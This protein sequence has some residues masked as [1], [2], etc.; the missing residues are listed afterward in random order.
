MPYIKVDIAKISSYAST[1]S[2]AEAK[3]N[4]IHSSFVTSYNSMDP[5]VMQFQEIS[6]RAQAIYDELS[7]ETLLLSRMGNFLNEASYQYGSIERASNL[8][9]KAISSV[10]KISTAITLGSLPKVVTNM[11]AVVGTVKK[12]DPIDKAKS[13]VETAKSKVG[14]V[15]KITDKI[16]DVSK[17]ITGVTNLAFTKKAGKIIVSGFTRK[18]VLNTITKKLNGG[19]GIGTRYKPS[20]LSGTKGIGTLYKIDKVATALK[21]TA[22]VIEGIGTTVDTI[23]KIR[24][25]LNDNTK[26]PKQKVCDSAAIGITTAASVGLKVAAPIVGKTVRGA[27]TALA[28][29][30]PV[31]GLNVVAGMVAGAAVEGIMNTVAEVVTSEAVVKQVSSSVAKVGDAAVAGVK[32]VSDAARAV[33]ES[34][35]A[36]EKVANTAKLVG[37]AVVAGAKVV[38][39]AV[40]E[41]VKVA[42]TVVKETVKTVA[43]KVTN[44]VKKAATAVKN[45]FKK[46]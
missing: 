35:N 41:G 45:F 9:D 17:K 38:S 7:K 2:S 23:G 16:Y 6:S 19:T 44:T 26:T 18:S 5:S 42:A 43:K 14:D 25:V 30:I 24:D 3:V 34:K 37:K 1:V 11:P 4:K 13:I 39:T 27:V 40:K 10:K 33:R 8:Q 21:T 31:P 15:K 36:K 32:T 28:T 20:T 12:A 29:A 22:K 46:W